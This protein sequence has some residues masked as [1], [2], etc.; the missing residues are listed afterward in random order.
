MT[1]DEC[2]KVV[3]IPGTCQACW[4]ALTALAET[5]PAADSGM[6]VHARALVGL[7]KTLMLRE[8]ETKYERVHVE[9]GTLAAEVS[10][11]EEGAIR[12]AAECCEENGVEASVAFPRIAVRVIVSKRV[13]L[14]VL[15]VEWTVPPRGRLAT[16][17]S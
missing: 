12:S 5:P 9:G 1:C 14:W 13:G 4:N 10:S 8:V 3:Q 2:G 16:P 15:R 11:L 7:L 6:L 17:G